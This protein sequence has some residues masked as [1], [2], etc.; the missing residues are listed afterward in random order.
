MNKEYKHLSIEKRWDLDGK[1]DAKYYDKITEE[2]INDFK[3]K[4]E[5]SKKGK[6]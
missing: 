4:I 3:K 6:K 2:E 1:L 5:E